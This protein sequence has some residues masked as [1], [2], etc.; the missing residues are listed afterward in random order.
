MHPLAVGPA[1]DILAGRDDRTA[2]R[3]DLARS[4]RLV[5]APQGAVLVLVT[6]RPVVWPRGAQIFLHSLFNLAAAEIWWGSH[7][8]L[9]RVRW[10]VLPADSQSGP[11]AVTGAK[12]STPTPGRRCTRRRYH[13]LGCAAHADGQGPEGKKL[14][15]AIPASS[16]RHP[17]TSARPSCHRQHRNLRRRECAFRL[18]PREQR[19][20]ELLTDGCLR[21]FGMVRPWRTPVSGA[22]GRLDSW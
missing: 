1:P 10:R 22:S 18:K 3:A 20:S 6:D 16:S 15:A 2:P 7:V 21:P 5:V 14:P 8:C 9:P 11:P 19:M 13:P 17:V 4:V 12:V